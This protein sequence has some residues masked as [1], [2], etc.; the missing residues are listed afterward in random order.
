M[1]TGGRQGAGDRHGAIIE[2]R[3]ADF[4]LAG[5]TMTIGQDE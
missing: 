1:V 5:G 3:G 4:Y 2:L